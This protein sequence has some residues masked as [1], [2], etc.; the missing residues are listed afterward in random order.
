MTPPLVIRASPTGKLITPAP[1]RGVSS[2][3]GSAPLDI[4]MLAAGHPAGLYV[5]SIV[6]TTIALG[7]GGTFSVTVSYDDWSLGPL[8]IL[9]SGAIPFNTSGGFIAPRYVT[10]SG[11]RA[12]TARFVPSAVAGAPR[13]YLNMPVDGVMLAAFPEASP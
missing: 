10:S 3:D 7:S 13:V 6:T 4:D 5:F 2:W 12:I 11:R 9:Y 8:S 1:A